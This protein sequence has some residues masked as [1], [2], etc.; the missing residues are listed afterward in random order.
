MVSSPHQQE[1]WKAKAPFATLVISGSS[2]K[3]AGTCSS[4]SGTCLAHELEAMSH[5][6]LGLGKPG[7]NLLPECTPVLG[8][9]S[10][11]FYIFR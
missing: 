9:V 5:A 11:E 8:L 3:V 7:R 10:T 4:I 1:P 6:S 2:Q